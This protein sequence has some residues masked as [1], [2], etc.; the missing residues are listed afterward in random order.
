LCSFFSPSLSLRTVGP[1]NRQLEMLRLT[2]RHD[3]R[4]SEPGY[5]SSACSG[6]T[7]VGSVELLAPDG[8]YRPP[9]IASAKV[10]LARVTN[11]GRTG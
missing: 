10:G 6:F 8:R 1:I 7:S 9:R 3:A 4:D 2:D 5:L 11:G